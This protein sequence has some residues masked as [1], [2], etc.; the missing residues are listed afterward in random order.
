MPQALPGNVG[1]ER[2]VHL[3]RY[4]HAWLRGHALT[5]SDL[6][7]PGVRERLLQTLSA[8][9]GAILGK[10]V[11]VIAAQVGMG[12]MQLGARALQKGVQ[13]LLDWGG[14]GAAAGKPR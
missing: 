9:L 11:S 12:A 6:A 3:E 13:K 8:D 2:Q 1:A 10:G 14:A 4:L 7:D 5:L